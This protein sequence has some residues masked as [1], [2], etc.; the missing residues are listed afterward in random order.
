MI[1]EV[2]FDDIHPFVRYIGIREIDE[3]R[4]ERWMV[5]R[6]NRL[7]W[8]TQGS[9]SIL[10][11]KSMMTIT[12]EHMAFIPAG[13]AYSFHPTS[14]VPLSFLSV[15]FD[16]VYCDNLGRYQLP[17]L[18]PESSTVSEEILRNIVQYRFANC[19]TLNDAFVT[20][21]DEN[22]GALLH[23]AHREF[24]YS[25]LYCQQMI[26]ALI[27]PVLV[28]AVRQLTAETMT[29]VNR[30]ETIDRI[31]DYI[32]QHYS[33]RI[34]LDTVAQHMGYNRDY[35]NRLMNTHTGQTIFQYLLDYRIKKAIY[36]I[37]STELPFNVIAEKTGFADASN[38]SRTFQNKTGKTPGQFRSAE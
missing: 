11:E 3:G 8:C 17:T 30:A 27:I 20:S 21:C 26:S 10:L 37:R 16:F 25:R 4:K 18:R 33:E 5:A 14:S 12:Q 22:M 2:S 13:T 19:D 24:F 31:I 28:S 29:K 9:G 35:L 7:F 38:L 23:Q 34:T 6:D 36:L 1:K 32:K 15:N